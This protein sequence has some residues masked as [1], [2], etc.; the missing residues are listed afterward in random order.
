VTRLHEV[1]ETVLGQ[2]EAFAFIADFANAS[3]WDPGIAT[4]EALDAGPVGV[5]K[6]FRLGVRQRGQVKPMEYRITEHLAPS[7]VVLV[8]EGSGISAV[9]AITFSPVPGGGTR[10]EY[11][12]DI[13]LGGVLRLAQPLLG[14]TLAKIARDALA[15]MKATLDA[16]AAAPTGE[17]P[18]TA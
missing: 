13:R 15:G 17:A 8:G 18:P 9:D 14:G 2:E 16:R 10:I 3:R 1:I 12:A 6:R 5:G 4:S 7:R 11:T